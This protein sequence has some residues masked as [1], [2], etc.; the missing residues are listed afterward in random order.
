MH[1]KWIH[2]YTPPLESNGVVYNLNSHERSLS[3]IIGTSDF[4]M[5][6]TNVT[7]PGNVFEYYFHTPKNGE[8][9]ERSHQYGLH[10]FWYK[11]NSLNHFRVLCNDSGVDFGNP[12]TP[13]TGTITIQRQNSTLTVLVNGVNTAYTVVSDSWLTGGTTGFFTTLDRPNIVIGNY[14]TS[15]RINITY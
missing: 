14:E 11:Y 5:H 3:P 9:W 7:N 4:T 6:F 12:S 8:T 13:F 10:L 15:G 1:H 2:W